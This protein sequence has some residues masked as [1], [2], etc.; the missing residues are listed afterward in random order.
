M[1]PAL[2]KFGKGAKFISCKELL[3]NMY[4]LLIVEVT[5]E[6]VKARVLTS[7]RSSFL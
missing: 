5:G 1:L 7:V 2:L 3:G 4:D 6:I